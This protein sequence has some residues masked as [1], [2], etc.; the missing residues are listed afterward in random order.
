MKRI[1]AILSVFMVLTLQSVSYAAKNEQ[2]Y[3]ISQLHDQI[4][5]EYPNG[6]QES[7]QTK[8]RMVEINTPIIVPDVDKMPILLLHQVK[9]NEIDVSLLPGEGWTSYSGKRI[10]AERA[11][12]PSKPNFDKM[13]IESNH[14]YAP[15]DMEMRL[16]DFEGKTLRELAQEIMEALECVNQGENGFDIEHP[17]D[18]MVN[19]A[20]DPK[21][22]QSQECYVDYLAYQTVADIPLFWHM[23]SYLTYDLPIWKERISWVNLLMGMNAY[24]GMRFIYYPLQSKTIAEDIPLMDFSKVQNT[25]RK[26]VEAGHIRKILEMRLGYAAVDVKDDPEGYTGATKPIW[27]VEVWWCKNGKARMQE[28]DPDY[29]TNDHG[30]LEYA[31]IAIDAQTGEI[32]SISG[33]AAPKQQKN[34]GIEKYQGYLSWEDVK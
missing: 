27:H 13:K 22:K 5:E 6:W 23:S 31:K 16:E 19:V 32:L 21:T 26:E 28:D 12:D 29:P 10:S 24:N 11:S 25:I 15:V 34:K 9:E 8:W 1:I 7:I 18:V 17:F 2:Y 14:Y 20:T 3:T 30:K 33:D 4:E